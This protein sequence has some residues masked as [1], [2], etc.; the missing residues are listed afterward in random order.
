[1]QAVIAVSFAG[2]ALTLGT[3]YF[4]EASLF[5]LFVAAFCS[6]THDIAADGFYMLAL[7]DDKQSFFVGIRSTFF[8]LAMISGEGLFVVLAGI[9][10]TQ[11]GSSTFSWISI[12][13]IV[14]VLMLVMSFYH[15][16]MLPTPDGD[17][18]VKMRG[19]RHL[20][21]LQKPL[22]I[23]SRKNRLYW[24]SFLYCFTDLED[25]WRQIKLSYAVA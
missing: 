21:L 14:A 13:G 4:F 25:N 23:S 17:F 3:P 24:R 20:M 5:F 11:S 16:V 8:R 19:N 7:S 6:S 15:K 10:A 18:A 1:M 9:I 12:L 22:S 2:A